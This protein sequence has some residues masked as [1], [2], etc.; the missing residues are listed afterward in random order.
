VILEKGDI[1]IYDQPE[2]PTISR[3][4]VMATIIMAISRDRSDE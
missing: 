4:K 3:L 2:E 1:N